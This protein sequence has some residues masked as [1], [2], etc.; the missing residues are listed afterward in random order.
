[1]LLLHMLEM[2]LEQLLSSDLA[3]DLVEV[4][5]CV[6]CIAPFGLTTS[7]ITATAADINWTAG[8]SETEWFLTANGS[9]TTYTTQQPI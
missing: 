2:P 8:G 7:N 5:A 4:N 1:M 6:S 9:G 3:I